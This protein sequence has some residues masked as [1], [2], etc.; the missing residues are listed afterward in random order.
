MSQAQ[1]GRYWLCAIPEQHLV[2]WP[3]VFIVSVKDYW[4]TKQETILQDKHKVAPDMVNTPARCDCWAVVYCSA[5][6]LHSINRQR[7]LTGNPTN[8][9]AA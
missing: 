2:P 8:D 1:L 6:A 4:Q 3:D 5:P 7:Q 9:A